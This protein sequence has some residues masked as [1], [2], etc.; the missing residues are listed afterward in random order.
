MFDTNIIFLYRKENIFRDEQ[1]IWK[2]GY[3]IKKNVMFKYLTAVNLV[4]Y[5]EMNVCKY[6]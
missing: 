6:S 5:K 1:Y 4:C 2:M 3:E